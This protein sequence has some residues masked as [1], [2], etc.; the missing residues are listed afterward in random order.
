MTYLIP[1]LKESKFILH[2]L[3]IEFWFGR[4][5]LLF[6]CCIFTLCNSVYLPLFAY[7][8]LYLLFGITGIFIYAIIDD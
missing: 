4:I 2:I 5:L 6:G 8:L 7:S 3:F 1:M